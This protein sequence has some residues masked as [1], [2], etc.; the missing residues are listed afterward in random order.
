MYVYSLFPPF[1]YFFPSLLSSCIFI[2]FL[3]S[4]SSFRCFSSCFPLD[5]TIGPLDSRDMHH[6]STLQVNKTLQTL[7]VS[8]YLLI[9]MFDI[10]NVTPNINVLP[11]K[12]NIYFTYFFLLHLKYTNTTCFDSH[13]CIFNVLTHP[14]FPDFVL[15]CV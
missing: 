1:N 2:C 9:Y 3:L 8:K 13:W 5:I 7:V 6:T 14:L 4:I 12:S 10:P 15:N 11:Y